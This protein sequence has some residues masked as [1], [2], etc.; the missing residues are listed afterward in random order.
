[1]AYGLA[2]F[3]GLNRNQSLLNETDAL[4]YGFVPNDNAG[5]GSSTPWWGKFEMNPKVQNAKEVRLKTLDRF[6]M[7]NF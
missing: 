7:R 1:M 2:R 5:N 3:E 6:A 4:S